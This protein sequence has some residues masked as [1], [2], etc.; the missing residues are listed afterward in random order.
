VNDMGFILLRKGMKEEA[1]D[2]F[3]YNASVHPES[4]SLYDSL[5]EGYDALGEKEL[6][7]KYFRIA[8]KM[9]PGNTYAAERIKKLL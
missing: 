9:D 2:I 7:L 3:G 4:A 6:A 1:V 8:L 5:G